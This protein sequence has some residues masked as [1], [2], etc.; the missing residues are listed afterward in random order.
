MS[1]NQLVIHT[2]NVKIN[3]LELVSVIL[4]N[5]SSIRFL[6]E[7]TCLSGNLLTIDAAR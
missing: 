5:I 2:T 6:Q 1:S 4:D 3:L 7:R